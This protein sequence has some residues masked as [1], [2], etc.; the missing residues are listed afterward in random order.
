MAEL[1]SHVIKCDEDLLF[2]MFW[3]NFCQFHIS[4]A[5]M[6]EHSAPR[7][8]LVDELHGLE[9]GGML[10]EQSLLFQACSKSCLVD[11]KAA[12]LGIVDEVLAWSGVT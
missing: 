12:S 5:K 8:Y 6:R 11:H 2:V 10:F 4:T 9:S 3:E 7:F 1:K